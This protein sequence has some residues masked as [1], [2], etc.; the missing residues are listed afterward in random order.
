[1]QEQDYTAHE[2]HVHQIGEHD[3]EKSQPMVKNKF[4]VLRIPVLA[5]NLMHKR[6]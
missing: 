2:D 6:V 1:M 4:I 5:T 3:Q